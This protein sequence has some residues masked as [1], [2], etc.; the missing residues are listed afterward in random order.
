M[1]GYLLRRLFHAL[2][3]LI[4]ISLI[5]FIILFAL[6]GDPVNRVAG[7]MALA[8]MS[9]RRAPNRRPWSANSSAST[10]RYGSNMAAMSASSRP[11]ISAVPSCSGARSPNSSGPACPPPSG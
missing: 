11:A 5:T 3:T 6:P 9:S 2:L 4:G 8:N 10:G 1:A 7:R